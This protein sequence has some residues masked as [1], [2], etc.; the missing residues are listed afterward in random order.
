MVAGCCWLL[1]VVAGCCFFCDFCC[2]FFVVV[3]EGASICLFVGHAF[4]MLSGFGLVWT[5]CDCYH[6]T[7]PSCH[8]GHDCYMRKLS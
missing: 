2:G 6:H 4:V 5:C 3:Q 8:L 7:L 1:L